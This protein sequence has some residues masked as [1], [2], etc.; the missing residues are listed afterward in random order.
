VVTGVHGWNSL[1]V[2]L[3]TGLFGSVTARVKPGQ[4][5][6]VRRDA[7]IDSFR[8]TA[9]RI[10][11][12]RFGVAMAFVLPIA[13]F[14]VV[15]F[16]WG[17]TNDGLVA[18]LVNSAIYGVLDFELRV[19]QPGRRADLH[20]HRHGRRAIRLPRLRAAGAR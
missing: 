13:Y 20:R 1:E 14:A 8:E 3:D 16:L 17:G 11:A 19:E 2:L 15:W 5:R 18:A 12:M 10:I 7:G 6:V 9:S 4:V